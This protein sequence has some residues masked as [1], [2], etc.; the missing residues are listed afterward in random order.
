MSSLTLGVPLPPAEA[1][2]ADVVCLGESSLDLV[3]VVDRFPEPDQK[4]DAATFELLTGGQAATAA[5]A[6]A[7]QGWRASYVG[8]LGDDV[9]GDRIATSLASERVAVSVVRRAGARS[10]SAMVLVERLTGR[11]TIIEHR[12]ARQRLLPGDVDAAAIGRARVV[13]VDATDIDASIAAA[14]H[15]RAAGIPTVVDVDRVGPEIDTLL[16]E[17]DILIVS[18]SFAAAFGD[19]GS[20]RAGLAKIA[21]QFRPAVAIATLGAEGSM[22]LCRGIEVR[23]TAPV[24]AAVD[25]TGAGDAFRGGFIAAWLRFGGDADLAL[26]LQY[27]NATAAQNCTGLGAQTALP[28]GE[29]VDDLVTRAYGDQSK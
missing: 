20:P 16:D 9:W 6:C 25:T 29:L 22:A 28:R 4:C 8:C 14:R 3:A 10:R 24:V 13:L 21:A 12:D 2:A 18:S 27:A 15:A 11:R 7:R 23:T 19:A 26:L 5:V 17:I 1:K